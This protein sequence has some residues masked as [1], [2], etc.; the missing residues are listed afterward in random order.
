MIEHVT[1]SVVPE[2]E[3]I[4]GGVKMMKTRV[5]LAISMFLFL[6]VSGYALADDYQLSDTGIDKC[7]NNSTQIPC[8]SPGQPFYGQDAQYEGRQPAYQDNG[9]GT[10]TDLNTNLMWQQGD[11]GIFRNWQEA[12][13]YCD[14]LILPSE[15]YSDWRLPDR[16]E[17]MSI[18]DYG[19][20][21]PAID[22]EVFPECLPS[23]IYWSSSTSAS[24]SN[25]AWSVYFDYGIVQ[26]GYKL[27]HRFVRCVR[28]GA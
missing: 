28:D 5:V 27:Y 21:Q 15:G 17:L 25:F 11:D 12:L 1:M 4:R 22:T 9:N 16:R 7:Y 3:W 24:S 18:V 14:A 13:D 2:Q 19:R 10:V 8:P 20:A 6:T 26:Y 23:R